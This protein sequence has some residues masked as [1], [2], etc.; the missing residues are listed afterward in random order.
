[1]TQ[2]R[3]HDVFLRANISIALNMQP[4]TTISYVNLLTPEEQALRQKV[5][6]CVEKEIA[7]IMIKVLP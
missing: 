4:H 3:E 6:A 5:R 7:P 1:M 2:L